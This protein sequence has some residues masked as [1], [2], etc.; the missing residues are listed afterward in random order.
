MALTGR[1]TGLTLALLRRGAGLRGAGC[2]TRPLPEVDGFPRPLDLG[3]GTGV[4]VR[5]ATIVTVRDRHAGITR[6][7][8]AER[9]NLSMVRRQP[10]PERAMVGL[11]TVHYAGIHHAEPVGQ[12]MVELDEWGNLPPPLEP[13]GRPKVTGRAACIGHGLCDPA[14]ARVSS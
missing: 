14:K 12:H 4:V 10:S 9:S 5:V 6:H 1:A 8:P 7:T 13:G 3:R 2:P 11:G